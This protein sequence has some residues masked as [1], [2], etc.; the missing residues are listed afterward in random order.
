MSIQSYIEAA[1]LL[2]KTGDYDEQA[3][4]LACMAVD[5]TAAQA[6][7]NIK[8]NGIRYKQFIDEHF[9]TITE[10]GFPGIS[11]DTILI[12]VNTPIKKL[13]PDADG[14]VSMTNIIYHALRCDL[15]HNCSIHNTITF[16]EHTII[17]NWEEDKFYLPKALINGLFAAIEEFFTTG[18]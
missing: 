2:A 11:A 15:V 7:P 9:R 10:Y 13:I 14:Y 6:Y 4:C 5:A 1:K 8:Q 16:T 17:G 18:K 12:K 3:L